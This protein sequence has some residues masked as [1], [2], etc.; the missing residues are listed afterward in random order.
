MFC[1]TVPIFSTTNSQNSV[2]P[3]YNFAHVH[4]FFGDK[5]E[6]NEVESYSL[7]QPILQQIFVRL[8]GKDEQEISTTV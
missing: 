5:K 8:A 6:K 4:K 7:T 2:K 1:Y 3:S